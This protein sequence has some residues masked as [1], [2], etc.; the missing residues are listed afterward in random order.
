ME[1]GDLAAA[2]LDRHGRFAKLP[3][4]VTEIRIFDYEGTIVRSLTK[5][6]YDALPREERTEIKLYASAAGFIDTAHKS[7]A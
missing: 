2:F 7:N 3:A 6:Q 5:A 1:P 4:D